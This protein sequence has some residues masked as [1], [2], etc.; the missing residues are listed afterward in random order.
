[1]ILALGSASIHAKSK[2]SQSRTTSSDANRVKADPEYARTFLN[3]FNSF[4]P[5]TGSW[6]ANSLS[7]TREIEKVLV[8]LRDDPNC[9]DI[10]NSIATHTQNLSYALERIE[11]TSLERD[12]FAVQRQ[13]S[14][15]LF[16]LDNETDAT[17]IAE[18]E[19]MF[20][21]NQYYLSL[22]E[23]KLQYDQDRADEYYQTNVMVNS[24]NQLFQQAA[25]NQMCLVKSPTLL[26]SLSSIGTSFAA[27][28]V[29]GG[30]SLGFAAASNVLGYVFDF[31][32]KSKINKDIQ[33]L[34][35][36]E[37]I[38]AYQCVLESL[39]NQ[40]CQAQEASDLINLK[41]QY[42]KTEPD[43]FSI[44]VRILNRELPVLIDWLG[45]VRA[46]TDPQNTSIS[47]R[48]ID[49]LNRENKLEGWRLKSI[50][51]LGDQ[52]EK[53]PSNLNNDQNK[54]RHF[55][56]LK[57]AIAGMNPGSSSPFGGGNNDGPKNPIL[58]TI[59]A[60]EV[61]WR[62]A[63]IAKSDI[64]TTTDF[65]G[66]QVLADFNSF[67]AQTFL[68]D[69]KLSQYYP[70][71]VSVISRGI[72]ELYEEASETLEIQRNN[73]LLADPEI[74]FWDAETPVNVGDIRGISPLESIDTILEYFQAYFKVEYDGL[75]GQSNLG[76][77]DED[78]IAEPQVDPLC[79][80]LDEQFANSNRERIYIQTRNMLCGVKRQIN[81]F[82]E[83]PNT[84]LQ[85]ISEIAFLE[86]GTTAI[87]DRIQ[88]TMRVILTRVFGHAEDQDRLPI[89]AKLLVVDDIIE[90]LT[91][92]GK[93]NLSL[94][95][96]DIEE[97]LQVSEMTLQNFAEIFSDGI[98]K[99]LGLVAQRAS[100][101]TN[102]QLLSKYCS[103]L[104]AVPDW[105]TKDVE[106]ID[107]SVCENVE[108]KSQWNHQRYGETITQ[109]SFQQD[110]HHTRRGCFLR[111]YLRKEQY[112]QNYNFQSSQR[113]LLS[114]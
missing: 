92:Y 56:L 101:S 36:V 77:Q 26:S 69:P 99:T 29:T 73:V 46:A 100:L 39:S 68:A 4:C 64:P 96:L 44:G 23:G 24:A 43:T 21:S 58:D 25:L 18:M 32:R 42:A 40:W 104:L 91:Q 16:L 76:S 7:A 9:Q 110:Y 70:L 8:N 81:L 106:K 71:D 65:G 31:I 66:N 72:D 52:K 79:P 20:R 102:N 12:V 53:L 78:V 113:K 62:I 63:G 1:M 82:A 33:K 83:E 105:N 2:R 97:S 108:L 49:F 109:Q 45:S 85:Q 27:A 30:A 48:Q 10:A 80:P 47:A 75:Y 98:S 37:F 59:D 54:E 17:R 15:L 107:L 86:E 35:Q 112:F 28:M 114:H 84:R 111:G 60:R 89:H 3:S 87:E 88:K 67:T 51:T 34:G 61:P 38:S 93:S 74:L 94:Q 90:E 55:T 57:N 22:E 50:A 19:T 13:Q 14:D 95:L 11:R 103:L 41:M 5:T 6:T